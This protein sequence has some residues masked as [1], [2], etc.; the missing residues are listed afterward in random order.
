MY[1]PIYLLTFHALLRVG[2]YT[3]RGTELGHTLMQDDIYF[4]I[5][6][7]KIQKLLIRLKHYKHPK[8]PV[9]LSLSP[10]L[11]TQYCPVI[12]L[13]TY[14]SQRAPVRGSLFLNIDDPPLTTTQFSSMLK[15]SVIDAGLNLNKYKP[16]NFRI[17]ETTRAHEQNLSESKIQEIG[18]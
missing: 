13:A 7:N 8:N 12:A 1:R 6:N 3:V 4:S 14:F 10:L 9:T 18:K 2:E 16:H 17:G 5:E 15:M 11:R